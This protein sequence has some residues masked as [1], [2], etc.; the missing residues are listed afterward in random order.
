MS[1]SP[2]VSLIVVLDPQSSPESGGGGGEDAAPPSADVA[3]RF[4]RYNVCVTFKRKDDLN[5]NALILKAAYEPPPAVA[6]DK[7]IS[8]YSRLT[9][10]YPK[11]SHR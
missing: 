11:L 4:I 8:G 10:Q 6:T 7:K 1:S 2:H 3:E 9:G 5:L